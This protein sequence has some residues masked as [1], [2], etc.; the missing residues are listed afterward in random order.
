MESVVF[1][2]HEVDRCSSCKGL[3]FDLV[4]HEELRDV[5]GSEAIDTGL[6]EVGRKSDPI[7]RIDCPVCKAPMIRMVVAGQPHIRYE[8][9]TVCY[10]VYFDA[11]EFTDFR[12][13]TLGES[14][15]DMLRR[16][17]S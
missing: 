1:Q 4:E 2:E 6:P 10:G 5:K 9:C 12:R 13:V 16:L 11:G 17:R 15:R 14:V 7:D 3:W 8:S